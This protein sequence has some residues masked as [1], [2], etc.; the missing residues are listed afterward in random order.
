MRFLLLSVFAVFTFT[1]KSQNH[2]HCGTDEMHQHL[3][4]EYPEMIPAIRNNQAYLE[5]FTRHFKN[6]SQ[7]Y[8]SNHVYII[9]VVF[10][11][12]HEYG[13]ENITDE[14]IYDAIEQ[15]NIQL[16][17]RNADTSD[18]VMAF[19]DIAADTEIEIR[20]A[21]KD[22][23]GNCTNGITRTVSPLTSPG[24]HGLKSL[25]QWPPDKYL[26]IYVARDAATLAGHAVMPPA[27]DTIPEWDGIVMNHSYVGT[28]GTSDFFRRTVLTHEIGHYLNLEHIWGGNNV[29]NFPYLV[30]GQDT[31]CLYDDGVD[32]TPL[33]KGWSTCNLNAESCGDLDNVQNYMDYAYCARMFTVGQKERMHATLNAPIAGRNNLWTEENLNLTGVSGICSTTF[34]ADKRTI[35]TGNTVNFKLPFGPGE[36][37]SIEWQFEGGSPEFSSAHNPSVIYNQPGI[38]NVRLRVRNG[39]QSVIETKEGFITVLPQTGG[40]GPVI[41]GFE[42]YSDLKETFNWNPSNSPSSIEWKINNSTGLNSNKSIWLNNFN[43]PNAVYSFQSNTIDATDFLAET[44]TLSFDV[45]YSRRNSMNNEILRVLTSNNCG[46]TW[47]QR[48]QYSGPTLETVAATTTEFFPTNSQW[49]NKQITIAQADKV[50]NLLIRFEFTSNSGNN[51]FIDNINISGST[52]SAPRV[53]FT[54]NVQEICQGQS[55]NFIN[56]VILYRRHAMEL[57]I[58]RWYA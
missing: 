41:E 42:N 55:V 7:N 43:A 16:R 13:A 58:F 17:K 29:P 4:S 12:I 54:S 35:C 48:A 15:T 45:A 10:H 38:Y 47:T 26:N 23:N 56:S 53:D 25:I 40:K 5:E 31:N 46:N 50:E 28:I 9:P 22:P 21:Q 37:Q 8:R 30:V 1:L 33:T 11:I 27:A 6:Y 49:S 20:L 32:D 44:L 34:F 3:I 14:Q 36:M 39:G 57:D 2:L 52:S 18:I 19:R 24:D 51:I